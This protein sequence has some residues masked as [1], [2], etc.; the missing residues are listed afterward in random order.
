MLHFTSRFAL[1]RQIAATFIFLACTTASAQPRPQL[2]VPYIKTPPAVVEHMLEMADVNGDDI[3]IDLGS[4]DGRI[5]IAAAKKHGTQGLG[6][7]LDPARTTEARDAA[8]TAGVAKQVSFRTE[9][10]FETDLEQATVI[11]MYLFP[12]INLRLRPD[13]LALTPGTRIV[14]HAFHMEDWTPERHDIVE[15]RD[16]FL[17]TVPAKVEGVWHVAA[18]NHQAFVLRLWQQFDRV[19]GI[20]IT[21]DERSVP[22]SVSIHG[23]DID[24]N[25]K[26]AAGSYTFSGKVDGKSM[27]GHSEHAGAWSADLM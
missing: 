21:R 15:G 1:F 14:S 10:L 24:F 25:L 18:D 8:T 27:T 3:L 26:T 16:I 7:D 4:G 5:P 6:V 17:W 12:E 19:Q 13:L 11:S 22:I 23:A 20:A 9:N 2:D